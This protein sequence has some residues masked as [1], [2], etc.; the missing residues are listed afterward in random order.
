MLCQPTSLPLQMIDKPVQSFLHPQPSHHCNPSRC[1]MTHSSF[2]LFIYISK[3]KNAWQVNTTAPKVTGKAIRK[4][5]QAAKMPQ[6]S[7]SSSRQIYLPVPRYI[8][9]SWPTFDVA[10]LNAVHQADLLYLSHDKPPGSRKVYK[11]ALIVAD[12]AS[13]YKEAEPLTSKDSAEVAKAFQSI[14][15]RG[16][17][18]WPQLLQVDPGREFIKRHQGNGK[19]QNIH[20]PRTH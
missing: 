7:G 20:S 1:S 3:W 16:P 6:S 19:P 4:L 15:K 2:A 11:Y 14:Y 8:H 18:K 10:T 13:R 5:A 17:S 12:V 9:V